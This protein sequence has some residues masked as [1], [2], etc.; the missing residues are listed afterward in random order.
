MELLN[1]LFQWLWSLIQSLL[2]PILGPF[3]RAISVRRVDDGS[4]P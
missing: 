4:G 1:R 2:S 3:T